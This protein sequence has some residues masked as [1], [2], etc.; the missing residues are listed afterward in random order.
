MLKAKTIANEATM[1]RDFDRHIGLISESKGLVG[2]KLSAKGG[3]NLQPVMVR[4]NV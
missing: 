4:V 2:F 3:A 1:L